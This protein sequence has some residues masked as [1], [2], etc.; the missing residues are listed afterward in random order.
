M[1]GLIK[2]LLSQTISILFSFIYMAPNQDS[3]LKLLYILRS[4]PYSNIKKI[5]ATYTV[6]R[7]PLQPQWFKLYLFIFTWPVPGLFMW[8][9]FFE[10]FPAI[11]HFF[12][13]ECQWTFAPHIRPFPLNKCCRDVSLTK[14]TDHTLW[15]K[16]LR[17]AENM[18]P[19]VKANRHKKTQ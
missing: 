6:K 1:F 8:K 11:S 2:A 9:H 13:I 12:L 18:N 10:S 15:M 16:S 4:R 5:I 14:T 19:W 7:W 3:C 17:L